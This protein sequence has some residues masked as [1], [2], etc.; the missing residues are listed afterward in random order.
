MKHKIMQTMKSRDDEHPLSGYVQL[1]DAYWGGVK[2]GK[3]GRGAGNKSPFV[4]AVALNEELHAIQHG[5]RFS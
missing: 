3:R 4:A 1:D 5:K 2:K